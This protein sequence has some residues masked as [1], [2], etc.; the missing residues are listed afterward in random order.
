MADNQKPGAV[1]Q[2]STPAPTP[3]ASGM[4]A[5]YGPVV[6]VVGLGAA[7]LEFMRDDPHEIIRMLGE[8]GPKYLMGAFVCYVVWDL[9]KRLLRLLGRGVDHIG[10]LADNTGQ[11]AKA[12]QDL[13][14]KSDRSAE[15]VRRLSSFAAQQSERAVEIGIENGKKMDLLLEQRKGGTP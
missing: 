4:A 9:L 12:I 11:A 14:T 6:G 1:T 5:T 8:F 3:P 7:A 2:S 15:E 10:S 13:A